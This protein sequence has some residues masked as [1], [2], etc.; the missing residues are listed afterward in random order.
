MSIPFWRRPLPRSHT[1]GSSENEN[2]SVGSRVNIQQKLQEKKQKQLA[3]LKIIEEE[4][5]QGKLGGPQATGT[6]SSGDDTGNTKSLPRQPIPRVKKH[7]DLEPLEW[8]TPSPDFNMLLSSNLDEVNNLNKFSNQNYDPIYNSFGLNG[9]NISALA[10]FSHEIKNN[11]GLIE[12]SNANS[13]NG[14]GNLPNMSPSTSQISATESN[15]L[16]RQF[17]NVQGQQQRTHNSKISHNIPRN[18][19]AEN[20]RGN[21]VNLYAEAAANSNNVPR[22]TTNS[23]SRTVISSPNP[24]KI[25]RIYLDVNHPRQIS[26][27]YS[28]IENSGINSENLPFPYNVV[29]PPRSKL[30]S[31]IIIQQQQSNQINN[32]NTSKFVLSQRQQMQ[33]AKTPEILLAPHYLENSRIY[34]DWVAARDPLYRYGIQIIAIFYF[35]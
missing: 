31:R 17:G 25:D 30:D 34:Y 12:T 27:T 9:I 23:P 35:P 33:R 18:P 14:G 16:T 4:I 29:P 1:G 5:K 28:S 10:K 24:T 7:I 22:N 32:L 19:F 13:G 26:G 20:Y 8:R 21:F 6:L 11:I 2:S 3:E 15:S